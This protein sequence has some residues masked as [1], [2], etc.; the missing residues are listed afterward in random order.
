MQRTKGARGENE[1]FRLL[2][3]ELGA[4]VRRNV[5]QARAGG[6]DGIEVPGWAVEVKR[7]ECGFRAEWWEQAIEQADRAMRLADEIVSPA[8]AYRASRQPWRVRLLL[9]DVAIQYAGIGTRAW[10]EM[11]LPTFALIVRE[12][13]PVERAETEREMF[14][15][16][17]MVFT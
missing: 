11:D 17:G 16:N 4:C 15:R 3:A 9:T 10:I 5:D 12:S 2:S 13:L 7:Q 1:F 6:A 8:L 14:K